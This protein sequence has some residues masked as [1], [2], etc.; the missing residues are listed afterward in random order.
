M[1]GSDGAWQRVFPILTCYVADYPKQCLVTC[2]K[3]GTCVKFQAPAKDLQNPESAE[4]R[5]QTWTK[6]ILDQGREQA[7]NNPCAF[8][9]YCMSFNVAGTVFKPFWDGSLSVISI[10]L[11]PQK[12][13][14]NFTKVSSNTLCHGANRS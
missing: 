10:D 12:F 2:T 1:V 4:P 8:H 6:N 7:N 11:L 3:Y 9:T 5:S 14:I 13:Y